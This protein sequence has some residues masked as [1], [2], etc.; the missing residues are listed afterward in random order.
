MDDL[1]AYY[2]G[3]LRNRIETLE[4]VKDTLAGDNSEAYESIRRIAHSLK[5]TGA[6]YGFLEISQT[7]QGLLE[8]SEE[9][10]FEA[11]EALLEAMREV[12]FAVPEDEAT[13]LI[14]EDD[15]DMC[16]VLEHRLSGPNRRI[17]TA[18]SNT[19]AAALL[20]SEAVD[21]ILLDLVL[22]GEDGRSLLSRLRGNPKYTTTP[23][24]V[25]SACLGS[26]SKME[27]YALGADEYFEKPVDLDSLSAAVAT[28]LLRA[29]E[30]SREARY[31]PMT[32]LLNRAGFAFA[33]DR[34]QALA[35]RANYPLSLALADLDGL[36][37][38]NDMYGHAL[39]DEVLLRV[40]RVLTETLRRSNRIA[41]WGGD[42]LAV[43]FS[44]G[45]PRGASR[46]L[47]KCLSTLSRETFGDA[48]LALRIG[49]SAGVADVG[50]GESLEEALAK[51][52]RLLYRAKAFGGHRIMTSDRRPRAV[53]RRLLL[54]DDNATAAQIK[55]RLADTQLDL[56]HCTDGS[57]AL[58][59]ALE[60]DI[61]LA[62]LAVR[63][64]GVG[65][66]EILQQLRS[67][68][69][70]N[71]MPVIVLTSVDSEEEV[72]TAFEL[73]ADDYL[74]KPF[75]ARELLARANRLLKSTSRR[76]YTSAG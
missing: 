65:G 67:T 5:G 69:T 31:D 30:I 22:P 29:N 15:P 70:H 50:K 37:R 64:P 63:V 36:K 68:A 60:N 19:E 49:F 28:K 6:T 18:S 58:E 3:S 71:E 38:I 66:L 9:S 27:C 14:V 61:A 57:S 48:D 56:L 53:R 40:A 44:D 75:S 21:L 47:E 46:A 13:I 59:M 39:G 41:R 33:F 32:R 12:A 54:V 76:A 52:D 73:G 7:A 34:A 17:V 26:Q 25:V 51:A 43:L 11:T 4:A 1:K 55:K 23:I 42:E 72:L 45:D 8:A 35:R 24:V 10:F 20:D 62:I 74:I 16:H 2:R